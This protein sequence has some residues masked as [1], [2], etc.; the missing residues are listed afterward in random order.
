MQCTCNH[1][2]CRRRAGKERFP[3]TFESADLA[4]SAKS[5]FLSE[6]VIGSLPHALSLDERAAILRNTPLS[7]TL[8][9]L[10]S[11]PG[12]KVGLLGTVQD[13]H[14]GPC[15]CGAISTQCN[16]INRLMQV[17][18]RTLEGATLRRHVLRG[19]VLVFV[20]A[21]YSGKR[22]VFEKAK[23]LGVRS[24]ILDGPDSWS[25]TLVT[26]G[27]AEKFVGI[28]FTDGET[29]FDRCAEAIQQVRVWLCVSLCGCRSTTGVIAY[30]CT[31]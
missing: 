27:V 30:S 5:N 28:D 21:G 31:S 25:Q 20:T 14:H 2:P 3:S 8:N 16:G 11:M 9:L 29:V 19:A 17:N 6:A 15:A 22:F 7:P 1:P 13:G 10:S 23:E 24:V 18:S 4:T 26:E 12:D